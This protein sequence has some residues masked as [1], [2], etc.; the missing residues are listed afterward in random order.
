MVDPE[1]MAK[2]PLWAKNLTDALGYLG[3][4]F[5][6]FIGSATII[7]PLPSFIL[8]FVMG[9]VMNPWLVGISAAA[10]NAIGELTGYGIGKGSGKLIEKKYKETL[11]RYKKWFKRDNIF[12]LVTIFAA[13][14]LPDDVVGIV[15]GVFNYDLKK[16]IV[17]SFLGKLILNLFLAWGGFY[18]IRWVLT[19]FGG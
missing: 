15:C 7:F 11:E 3:I 4:F 12:L 16:F 17:A 6:S 14:P 19:F 9:A 10:G 5:V 8:V 18:G 2:I 1:I 13:T